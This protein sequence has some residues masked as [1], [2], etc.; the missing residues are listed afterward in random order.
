MLRGNGSRSTPD[1]ILTTRE[2]YQDYVNL[3]KMMGVFQFNTVTKRV[4]F[5]TGEAA[6]KGAEMFWD[7]NCPAGCMYFLNTST[8]QFA[9]DPDN[10]F[11]MTEWKTNEDT[12]DRT[13]QIVAVGNLIC[14]NFQKNGV[15]HSIT[16]ESI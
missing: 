4:D 11:E 3:A 16:A 9:Y 14:D 13:A 15:I 5:G 6:F 10:W 7:E 1:I 12:L 8:M 2:I